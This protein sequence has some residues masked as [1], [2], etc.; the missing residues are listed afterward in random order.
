MM[1][2]FLFTKCVTSTESRFVIKILFSSGFD[3]VSSD[4]D[5]D[6]DNNDDVAFMNRFLWENSTR[7]LVNCDYTT[8]L[9]YIM[10]QTLAILW[11]NRKA[12]IH[13]ATST[14]EAETL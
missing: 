13:N 5:F 12:R 7:Q 2:L 8:L 1:Q 9:N 10:Y 6:D 11:W 14:D 4:L 3:L